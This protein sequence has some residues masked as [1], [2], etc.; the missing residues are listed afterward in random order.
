MKISQETLEVLKNFSV[1]NPSILINPG[2]VLRTLKPSR[3]VYGM[4]PVKEEF[5]QK[6]PLYDLSKFLSVISLFKETEPE[7]E[8]SPTHLKAS[9]GKQSVNFTLAD[10]SLITAAPESFVPPDPITEFKLSAEEFQ[11]ALKAMS[12][13]GLSEL[14]IRNDEGK[15]VLEAIDSNNKSKDTYRSEVGETDKPFNVRLAKDDLTLLN[16]EYSV[17]VGEGM[18]SFVSKDVAYWIATIS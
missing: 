1:I 4:A 15:I 18:V 14:R 2:K 13:M 11:K 5:Q 16:K 6:L 3:T 9:A 10:A 12:V 8:I 17:G 7:F